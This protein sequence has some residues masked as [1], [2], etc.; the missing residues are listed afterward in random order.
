MG[1]SAV[2]VKQKKSSK[3][4]ESKAERSARHTR[5]DAE[6]RASMAA[7]ATS[8]KVGMGVLQELETMGDYLAILQLTKDNPGKCV[9]IDFT[10]KWCGPCQ[11]VAPKFKE[12]AKQVWNERPSLTDLKCHY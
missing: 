8:K 11:Q 3:K 6:R 7:R 12:A 2:S 9:L 10:A 1:Q 5:E 4:I